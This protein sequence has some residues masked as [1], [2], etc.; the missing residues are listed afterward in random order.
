MNGLDII[1]YIPSIIAA[2]KAIEEA[3]PSAGAG[4]Q[5]L[6]A[7]RGILESLDETI[8]PVWPKIEGIIK[9]LVALF[10]STIWKK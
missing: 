10:N 5:K 9:T 8:V 1:K 4:E 6:A 3:I 7:V 2:I